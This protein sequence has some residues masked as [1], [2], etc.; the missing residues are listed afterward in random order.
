MR[1]IEIIGGGP[2]GSAAAISAV[3]EGGTVQIFEKS[4]FP[5]HKV[6]GEF[7]SPEV[8]KLLDGLRVL[9]EFLH[10]NPNP[11]RKMALHFGPRARHCNLPE[12][13][14]GLSRFALDQLLLDK[15]RS[16]GARVIRE[17]RNGEP[18]DTP[19]IVAS[20]RSSIAQ[21]GRRLFG[22]KA[23]YAGPVDDV[24]ELFFFNRC[25]VGVSSVENGITNV[26][27]LAPESVLLAYGFHVDELVQGFPALN[28][29]LQPLTRRME[30]LTTGPVV[31]QREFA[32]PVLPCVYRAGDALGFTDPF[33]GSG[34]LNAL[35]TGRMAGASAATNRS[36]ELYLRDCRAALARPY[37]VSALFRIA[38]KAGLAAPL[39]ALIPSSA[40]FQL[41]RPRFQFGV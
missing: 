31:Y 34:V 4:S 14:Y 18:S 39:S 9:D 2:A 26:C 40:L 36:S 35:L 12:P 41:T 38:L 21:R 27:G 33:T 15:A 32:N 24:V 23:H 25:Y 6:C 10:L 5:R 37:L 22:F 17:R 3:L 30:W 11:I 1:K 19:R 28:A 13:A 8:A 7:L 29:R 16:L 20:G